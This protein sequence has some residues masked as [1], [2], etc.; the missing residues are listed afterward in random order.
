[1]PQPVI[2]AHVIM[3]CLLF[4]PTNRSP[5]NGTPA[6]IHKNGFSSVE[7]PFKQ[8]TLLCVL[9][10][11]GASGNGYDLTATILATL[12]AR[13]VRAGHRAAVRAFHQIRR[14]D[15]L[16][17]AAIATAMARYFALR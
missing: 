13:A 8:L 6:I 10:V 2:A 4:G 17:A 15:V 14:G 7:K 9:F 5:Y 16:V 3:Y 12:D 11:V 1:M